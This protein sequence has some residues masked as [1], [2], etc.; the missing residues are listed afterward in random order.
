MHGF[1]NKVLFFTY[2]T[3]HRFF[4]VKYNQ[5]FTIDFLKIISLPLFS[6]VWYNLD[7]DGDI[8]ISVL[9]PLF[10]LV[11]YNRETAKSLR[12]AEFRGV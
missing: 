5:T 7:R 1:I 6:L 3:C 2:V 11:W 12:C 9:V 10:S 4:D 8:S